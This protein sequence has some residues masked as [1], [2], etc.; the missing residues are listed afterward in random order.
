[1]VE[2]QTSERRSDLP[3]AK[4]GRHL[5]HGKEAAEEFSNNSAVRDVNSEGFSIT[6]LPAASAAISGIIAS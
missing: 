3:V 1:M 6:R 5:I 4:N 2:R